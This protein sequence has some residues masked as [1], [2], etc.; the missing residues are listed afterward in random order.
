VYEPASD[1]L[2]IT[3]PER[4]YDLLG[5]I[6]ADA[7][8]ADPSPVAQTARQMAFQRGDQLGR[9]A[10]GGLEAVL[11]D[12]GF[13]PYSDHPARTLLANCPF[14]SVA[15]R[16]TELVC[17]INL[18]FVA[19]LLNGLHEGQCT[20]RLAPRAGACCVEISRTS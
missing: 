8:A 14:H 4:R 3:I 6:L 11:S 1:G 10:T 15:T 12:L 19:G 18:A 16:Q 9:N 5:E 17:G 20:A 7:V 2:A 13:E